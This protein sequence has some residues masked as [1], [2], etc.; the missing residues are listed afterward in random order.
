MAR[1]NGHLSEHVRCSGGIWIG[2]WGQVHY[3]MGADKRFRKKNIHLF[4]DDI[5]TLLITQPLNN[6]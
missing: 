6:Y 4:R 1:C 3:S 5:Q 2:Y